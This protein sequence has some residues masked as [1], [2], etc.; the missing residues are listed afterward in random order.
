MVAVLAQNERQYIATGVNPWEDTIHQINPEMVTDL[1]GQRRIST[2]NHT[3][4]HES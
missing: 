4:L 3:N 1:F 2:T